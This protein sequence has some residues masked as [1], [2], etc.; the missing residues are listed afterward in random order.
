MEK[1]TLWVFVLMMI[2]AL[3][4]YTFGFISDGGFGFIS[5]GGTT[6]NTQK[7]TNNRQD[8]ELELLKSR[9]A[10]LE[11]QKA[12]YNNTVMEDFVNQQV[13]YDDIIAYLMKL[14][15]DYDLYKNNPGICHIDKSTCPWG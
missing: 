11:K 8:T 2:V 13:Q 6:D 3:G 4:Y 15:G 14:Q 5:G 9:V 12:S 10:T 7:E 1:I